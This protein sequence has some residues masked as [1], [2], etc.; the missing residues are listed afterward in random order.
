[1]HK[2]F[3]GTRFKHNNL[4]YVR[5]IWYRYTY[6]NKT[7]NDEVEISAIS[8]QKEYEDFGNDSKIK[9]NNSSNELF[10]NIFY[11]HPL[12]QSQKL[13]LLLY[14]RNVFPIVNSFL[15]NEFEYV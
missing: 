10:E 7:N 13:E 8:F 2:E 11:H 6:R 4:I 12:T 5:Y 1:M 14:N 15:E 3:W 9:A